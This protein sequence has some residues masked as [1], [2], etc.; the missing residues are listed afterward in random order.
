MYVCIL[1]TV[2]KKGQ[3]CSVTNRSFHQI[4]GAPG[5]FWGMHVMDFVF[6]F[7]PHPP[8]SDL[9]VYVVLRLSVFIDWFL[10]LFSSFSFL[11]S[12]VGPHR[13]WKL[14]GP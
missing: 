7:P 2:Q 6:V 1:T 11:L 8:F 5:L 14:I 3:Y 13:G 9:T 10:L 12:F 4:Y